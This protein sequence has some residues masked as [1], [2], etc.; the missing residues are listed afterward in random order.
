MEMN[1]TTVYAAIDGERDHQDKKWGDIE[2]HPHEVGSW[3]LIMEAL[4]DDARK[5]WQ[6][7][8]GSRDAL[9]EIRKAVAVGVAAMEQHGVPTREWE[10]RR[11]DE[12]RRVKKSGLETALGL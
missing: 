7:V 9:G 11:K 3:I 8:N 12:V 2:T 5:A 4:L 10:E 1:R 6:S